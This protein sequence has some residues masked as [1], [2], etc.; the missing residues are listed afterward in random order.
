MQQRRLI[1]S[2]AK[3]CKTTEYKLRGAYW[4]LK[5]GLWKEQISLPLSQICIKKNFPSSSVGKESAGNAGDLVQEDS[6]EKEMATHSS[7][8]AWRIPPGQRSLAG[9]SP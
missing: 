8:H 2:G 3:Y 4:K 5:E 9:Y 1:Q 7:I 6:L